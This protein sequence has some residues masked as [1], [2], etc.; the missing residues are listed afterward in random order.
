MG[1]LGSGGQGEGQTPP[2]HIGRQGGGERGES[3]INMEGEEAEASQG[4]EAALPVLHLIA[5]TSCGVFLYLQC[6]W[7]A[8][9]VSDWLSD[10]LAMLDTSPPPGVMCAVCRRSRGATA[11]LSIE[12][13]VFTIARWGIWASISSVQLT[14][15]KAP[16]GLLLGLFPIESQNQRHF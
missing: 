13:D 16:L 15:S 6:P 12:S 2:S 8:T 7:P 4:G 11:A 14:A 3:L 10:V 5:M 1:S 9:I